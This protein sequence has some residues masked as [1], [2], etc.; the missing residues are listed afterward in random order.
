MRAK[1]ER[2]AFAGLLFVIIGACFA[3]A[4]SGYDFG[5][6]ANPGPGY[7]PF[8]LGVLLTVLGAVVLFK[9]TSIETR[10]GE[11]VGGIGWRPLLV[12]TASIVL[13]GL[14]L[15]RLGLPISVALTAQLAALASA[16]TR[17]RESLPLALGLAVFCALVFVGALKLNLPLWPV[18]WA[19]WG[20]G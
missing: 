4:A 13:F 15:P 19:Q 2:D 17:W 9:A 11:R 18:P 5:T 3:W 7:F 8:G 14:M 12:V 20:L 10:D 6:S 16:E 1:S